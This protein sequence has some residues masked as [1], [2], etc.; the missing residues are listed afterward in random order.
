MGLADSVLRDV[1]CFR[2]A[3]PRQDDMTLLI[4]RRHC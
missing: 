2:G 4:V 3:G 1:T